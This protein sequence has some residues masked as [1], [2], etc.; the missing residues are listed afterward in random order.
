M[1]G[2]AFHNA[3]P[4]SDFHVSSTPYS[5]PFSSIISLLDSDDSDNSPSHALS[6][7]SVNYGYKTS[8]SPQPPV[9]QGVSSY[10]GNQAPMQSDPAENGLSQSDLNKFMEML[11]MIPSVAES[12][13]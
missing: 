8:P 10:T 7:S 12:D 1:N 13:L 2:S 11:E 3:H 9:G 4:S 6:K 5:T